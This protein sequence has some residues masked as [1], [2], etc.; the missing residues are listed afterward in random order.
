MTERRYNDEETAA[1]L[2][3]AA[4]TPEQGPKPAHAAEGFSLAELQ[5]IAREVG[6]APDAVT[7]A[8]TAL[9]VRSAG[10]T[11]RMLG[12]PI[13]VE[14]RVMLNRKMTDDEWEQLV[15]E[16]RDVF[17]ARGR[18][19]TEGSL[20]QWTNG[21]LYVLL[22]PT[23]SGHRLRLGSVHGGAA[24]SIRL[25]LVAFLTGVGVTVASVFGADMVSTAIP[26][27]LG[28]GALLANG[29]LR[30]PGWARLR[31]NQMER[32]AAQLARP[33]LP[34]PGEPASEE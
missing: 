5:A 20:R 18:V 29:A 7:Q 31:S 24:A 30:V 1:I 21:N 19:R 22:E 6:I 16:L 27:L 11:R 9:E 10:T 32:L 25:G 3:I 15:V 17:H 13:G 14:R 2:R 26:L 4:E 28:G 8:A 33:M 23:P 12:L 34:P